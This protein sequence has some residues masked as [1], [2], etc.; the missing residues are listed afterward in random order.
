LSTA[1]IL[2][3]DWDYSAIGIA[4]RSC[5]SVRFENSWQN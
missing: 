1:S 2:T 3:N 4:P 5:L